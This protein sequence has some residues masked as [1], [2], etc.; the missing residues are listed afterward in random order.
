MAISRFQFGHI[1][2]RLNERHD[3]DL[4]MPVNA[5]AMG[6]QNDPFGDEGEG[7]FDLPVT[8][9]RVNVWDLQQNPHLSG[10]DSRVAHARQGY[11][12]GSH[13]IPPVLLVRRA[14]E[15]EIADGHHRIKAAK[16]AKKDTVPAWVVHSPRDEPHPGFGDY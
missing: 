7:S 6:T 10:S 12:E 15:Y 4:Y 3:D 14:G 11:E 16:L 1:I 13:A 8:A 5:L 2:D 9:E